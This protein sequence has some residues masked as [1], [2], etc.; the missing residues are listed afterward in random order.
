MKKISFT[1]MNDDDE[2]TY[3]D[4]FPSNPYLPNGDYIGDSFVP[5]Y[6]NPI[7]N[8]SGAITLVETDH[9]TNPIPIVLATQGEKPK[10]VHVNMDLDQP[11][12]LHYII[13]KAM[14]Y[15]GSLEGCTDS[16]AIH[17]NP[18][19]TINEGECVQLRSEITSEKAILNN[20]DSVIELKLSLNN[21]KV[22]KNDIDL[23]GEL[24]IRLQINSSE[25]DF[26]AHDDTN[27]ED[28]GSETKG[29]LGDFEYELADGE[30]E[31]I[32]ED[33]E[34]NEDIETHK[35]PITNTNDEKYTDDTNDEN[36]EKYNNGWEEFEY[37]LI[38]HDLSTVVSDSNSPDYHD[39]AHDKY[40][41]NVPLKL[42]DSLEALTTELKINGQIRKI[43]K[44]GTRELNHTV[45]LN[46]TFEL[47]G[48]RTITL[49]THVH[50][51]DDDHV[52][53]PF[54]FFNIVDSDKLKAITMEG[55]N[56][57]T[58]YEVTIPEN[59]IDEIG[60]KLII[61]L[62]VLDES[63]ATMNLDSGKDHKEFELT[64][65][66]AECTDEDAI[67]YNSNAN[68]E[69]L[70]ADGTLAQ[71]MCQYSGCNNTNADNY[72]DGHFINA[73]GDAIDKSNEPHFI[74]ILDDLCNLRV[75]E[76]T[77]ASNYDAD[78]TEFI[79]VGVSALCQYRKNIELIVER[80]NNLTNTE[81]KDYKNLKDAND[82]FVYYLNLDQ[83]IKIIV[84]SDEVTLK[85]KV[86][87]KNGAT[88]IAVLK[89]ADDS[90]T[91]IDYSIN[92]ALTE[93]NHT[94][95]L[96]IENED[97]YYSIATQTET[98][99]VY[100]RHLK[101]P[102]DR[103]LPSDTYNA[104]AYDEDATVDLIVDVNT[105]L[106]NDKVS[107]SHYP[108]FYE[109]LKDHADEQT[110]KV[111]PDIIC[112][113]NGCM[114]SN[115]EDYDETLN[116][117]RHDEALCITKTVSGCTVEEAE[118]FDETAHVD[119]GS[120]IVKGCVSESSARACNYINQS[121]TKFTGKD[122]MWNHDEDMCLYISAKPETN[123]YT[124]DIGDEDR[125]L[126]PEFNV[127][128]ITQFLGTTQIEDKISGENPLNI[129]LTQAD[130]ADTKWLLAG[131]EIKL[132]LASGRFRSVSMLGHLPGPD[133]ITNWKFHEDP[134]YF[135]SN[136]NGTI[137]YAQPY[138]LEFTTSI[139]SIK[140]V[141]YLTSAHTV[142]FGGDSISLY[143][144]TRHYLT[145]AGTDQ[146]Y[147][148]ERKYD[149]KKDVQGNDVLDDNGN[150]IKLDK[151]GEPL[152]DD[153]L[154]TDKC[155]INRISIY[156]AR[157]DILY[158]EQDG[159][160]LYTN[161]MVKLGGY[162]FNPDALSYGENNLM[163]TLHNKADNYFSSE[164]GSKFIVD[165]KYTACTDDEATNYDSLA[166]S[167]ATLDA[168]LCEYDRCGVEGDGTW[169]S[170]LYDSNCGDNMNCI[171]IEACKLEVCTD[172]GADDYVTYDESLHIENN[173]LCRFTRCNDENATNYAIISNA[174][175]GFASVD[176]YDEDTATDG[177]KQV[178]D[179]AQLKLF[180][181]VS[182]FD[183]SGAVIITSPTDIVT[184]YVQSDDELKFNDVRLNGF[185]E[186]QPQQSDFLKADG[187]TEDTEAYSAAI[188]EYNQKVDN[189]IST[190]DD[191]T[192]IDVN[193]KHIQLLQWVNGIF[194]I[195]FLLEILE[196]MVL[197]QINLVL[198]ILLNLHITKEVY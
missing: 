107:L 172:K 85:D 84:K 3:G 131:E 110:D 31:I 13:G 196:L 174:P 136:D 116:A 96:V 128:F 35:A 165:K 78:E 138:N 81:D 149:L 155:A 141:A 67:N 48:A 51:D 193:N 105:A 162:Y 125:E 198:L 146:K 7:L 144:M 68:K 87:L 45:S 95:S 180:N 189:E 197:H 190:N 171:S 60:D 57:M 80:N 40:Y 49:G 62:E 195:Y 183:F 139:P 114:D 8:P 126:N 132:Q 50:Q 102:Q 173:S 26:S 73:D 18:A 184:K 156:D 133:T 121:D 185:P 169:L 143:H 79:R 178:V 28:H 43:F 101:C 187:V 120:C 52:F 59:T 109:I 170:H 177:Y 47:Y 65:A 182:S 119:D 145:H 137:K 4:V 140:Y 77:N 129:G 147:T 176:D 33:G 36:Y 103:D 113:I 19:A 46:N 154:Y 42:T 127:K 112:E 123:K 91:V 92:A 34:F 55:E 23:Q 166:T 22:N 53:N 54:A 134:L 99:V 38:I 142:G 56:I 93:G 61:K 186:G 83:G 88:T 69:Q 159:E 24:Q 27:H 117:T 192:S 58:T 194:N 94:I 158:I 175:L 191:F 161:F 179:A 71:T 70:E 98:V 76:D 97:T 108:E 16:K 151:D 100:A 17:Y 82:D 181:I 122:I 9:S 63:G 152:P 10:H 164:G 104:F 11:E 6:Q 75:C 74:E 90:T 188:E 66:L 25:Y 153:Y 118:E 160:R 148:F 21:D 72:T 14:S 12:E 106:N 150:T 41:V 1:K 29:K 111:E 37:N 30:L 5:L 130:L 20:E 89:E 32:L 168:S 157:P 44:D 2:V 124:L 64:L 86:T 135:Q 15:V 163:L 39:G 167:D 115:F